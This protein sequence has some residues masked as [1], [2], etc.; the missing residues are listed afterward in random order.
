MSSNR[1]LIA[2]SRLSDLSLLGTRLQDIDLSDPANFG[3]PNNGDPVFNSFSDLSGNGLNMGAVTLGN[4]PIFQTNVNN[5]IGACLFG[6]V[7]TGGAAV[8]LVLGGTQSNTSNI[9]ANRASITVYAVVRQAAVPTSN[10]TIWLTTTGNNATVRA[11]LRTGMPTSLKGSVAGRTQ[12]GDTLNT[13][14]GATDVGTVMRVLS[15]TVNFSAGTMDLYIDGRPDGSGALASS[16][17]SQNTN[18]RIAIG[19]NSAS[20]N[21]FDGHLFRIPVFDGAHNA[22]Q[23]RAGADLL[24]NLY[25][26]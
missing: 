22:A 11:S 12:N 24:R 5:S 10:N 18:G 6:A 2:G 13:V 23:H 26:F 20:S 9:A 17:N 3:N 15:A 16:G 21:L 4:S 7:G 1:I 25:E 8:Q 19:S 14:G